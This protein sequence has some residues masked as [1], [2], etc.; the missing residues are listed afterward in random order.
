[1]TDGPPL[2]TQ[3][4]AA[5]ILGTT[6][7]TVRRAVRL[8]LGVALAYN[9]VAVSL[10]FAGVMSPVLCAIVMPLSSLSTI[11]MTLAVMRRGGP[12]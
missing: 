11:A 6:A 8:N 7:R 3:R 1:M 2:I 4:E 9:A 12:R 10:A 5:A